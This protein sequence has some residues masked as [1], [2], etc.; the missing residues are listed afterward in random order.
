M[1]S[2]YLIFYFIFFFAFAEIFINNIMAF[3]RLTLDLFNSK[4]YSRNELDLFVVDF[5]NRLKAKDN[6]ILK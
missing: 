1:L 5:L 4:L 2:N 3:N 6:S